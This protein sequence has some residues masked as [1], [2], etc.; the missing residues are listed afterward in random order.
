VGR[1]GGRRG[2]RLLSTG[3]KSSFLLRKKKK[4]NHLGERKIKREIGEA[5]ESPS[6]LQSNRHSEPSTTGRRGKESMLREDPNL[7]KW[8]GE[9]G[10]TDY[11]LAGLQHHKKKN[12]LTVIRWT[13]AS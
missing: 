12:A 5:R 11:L 6:S 13:R 9:G 10:E 2:E 1:K 4:S 3:P 7:G 8:R